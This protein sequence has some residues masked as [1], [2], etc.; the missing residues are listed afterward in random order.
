MT[1]EQLMLSRM[2]T[3]RLSGLRSGLPL[4]HPL[5]R[6]PLFGFWSGPVDGEAPPFLQAYP[7]GGQLVVEVDPAAAIKWLS[8]LDNS[9]LSQ[10]VWL[11]MPEPGSVPAD[12]GF[13][14]D[15]FT[16]PIP[17]DSPPLKNP[18]FGM[19]LLGHF[20]IRIFTCK[21]K[22]LTVKYVLDLRFSSVGKLLWDFFSVFPQCR[23]RNH[24]MTPSFS[25]Q[26]FPWLFF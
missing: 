2:Q 1:L 5:V 6:L 19:I 8:G 22:N 23:R 11:A 3:L 9:E 17:W 16:D 24:A 21:S 13:V 4:S 20:F 10:L 25:R 26:N 12:V 14:G 7:E 18:P 15:F